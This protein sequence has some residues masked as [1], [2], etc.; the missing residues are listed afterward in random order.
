LAL[1]EG[2]DDPNEKRDDDLRQFQAA[3]RAAID[4]ELPLHVEMAPPGHTDLGWYTIFPHC[5]R[6]KAG[7]PVARWQ[8]S[9]PDELIEC[10]VCGQ[11]Y[12]PAKTHKAE[13]MDESAW[14]ANL[15][16]KVLGPGNTDAFRR[17]F[18]AHQGHNDAQID[19]IL[20]RENNGPLKRRIN[21]LRRRQNTL[22]QLLPGSSSGESDSLPSFLTLDLGDGVSMRSVLI[23]SGDFLM[24]TAGSA[25]DSGSEGPQHLVRIARPFYLGEFPVTQAQFA[26]V[27]DCNP[28]RFKGDSDR[29]VEKTSWF[30][31]QEFCLRL[32]Q[33][34][35]RR[36]RLPSESEWEYASRAGVPSVY[37][38]GDKA[39]AELF[40]CKT[41]DPFAALALGAEPK[42]DNI[43]TNVQGLFPPNAWGLYD[44]LGNVQEWCEDEW[45][46][47]YVDAPT[48]GSAW[49]TA[50]DENPFRTTRG[51]SCWHFETACT[52]AARQSLRADADDEP[53]ELPDDDLLGLVFFDQAPIGFRVVIE[54][55]RS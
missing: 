54:P 38:W 2:I 32:S 52:C 9:Y 15:L 46:N 17:R 14:D 11:R 7:A 12:S 27:M 41:G 19:H 47:N 55:V 29:P 33:K 53:Q 49:I 26:A 3:L 31:A 20:D 37:A 50:G 16:E 8:E 1:L 51:G 30:L 23:H 48:D 28:S 25:D 13:R 18:L 43:I 6:C 21:E 34:T 10:P 22:C 4:W 42:D 44:M 35:R 40:N 36:V 45:H 24:G 5:P 39:T